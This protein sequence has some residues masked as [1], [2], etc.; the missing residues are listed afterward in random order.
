MTETGE[1]RNPEMPGVA[2]SGV[3]PETGRPRSSEAVGGHRSPL[4]DKASEKAGVLKPTFME[5]NEE[6][7]GKK[8]S[9]WGASSRRRSYWRSR[10]YEPSD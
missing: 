5:E 2:T 10:Y 4:E 3:E 6:R 8:L 9:Q 7:T 1:N